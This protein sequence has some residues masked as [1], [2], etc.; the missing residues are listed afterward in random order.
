M[1][2][3]KLTLVII[4]TAAISCALTSAFWLV[5]FNRGPVAPAPAT[6]ASVPTVAAPPAPIVLAPSGL[7]LPVAGVKPEELVDTYSAARAGGRVHDATDIMA[8]RGTAVVAAAP[9][10]VEKLFF[11]RGGGGITAYVRSPDGLWQYYY[12]HLDGYA[13]GLHE[14]QIVK[15]G[16]P[17][18]RVGSTGDASPDAPHLHFAINRMAPG[19]RWWQGSPINP[20]PLLAGRKPGG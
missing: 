4:L 13:P 18:G 6:P 15:R 3:L 10:T 20:Y 19:Q 8:P 5:A 17:I 14:G 7:A 1:D 9:G 2:R 12:A 16:D 11:S